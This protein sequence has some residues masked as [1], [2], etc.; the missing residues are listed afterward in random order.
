M[1]FIPLQKWNDIILCFHSNRRADYD[2][3]MTLKEGNIWYKF[4]GPSCCGN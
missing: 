2:G 1:R 4:E 3:L